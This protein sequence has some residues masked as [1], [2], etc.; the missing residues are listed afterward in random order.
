MAGLLVTDIVAGNSELLVAGD[1]QLAF[2]I[3]YPQLGRQPV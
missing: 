2:M 3:G 1:R